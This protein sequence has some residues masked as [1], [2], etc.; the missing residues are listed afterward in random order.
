MFNIRRN[1]Y[2]IKSSYEVALRIIIIFEIN[3]AFF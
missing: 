2:N 3:L 1:L